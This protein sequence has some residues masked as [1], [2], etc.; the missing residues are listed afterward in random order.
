MKNFQPQWTNVSVSDLFTDIKSHFSGTPQ[1]TMRFSAPEGMV[2]N[3]DEYF[4]KTIMRNLTSNAIK[5]LAGRSGGT[6]E[7]LARE[8]EGKQV[9][10]ITDNG[11][12]I[13][14]SQLRP[15]YDESLPSSLKAGLGL[16]LVRDL[17]KA[18][19]RPTV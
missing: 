14:E 12:G 4:L 7:W 1:V 13:T 9:L 16:H 10:S 6:I 18:T 15:L 2:L 5:S 17:S 19:G 8:E 3:T 11:P